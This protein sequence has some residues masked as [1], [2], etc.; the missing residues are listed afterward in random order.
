MWE[1][2][3]VEEEH[4]YRSGKDKEMGD[5]SDH[6]LFKLRMRAMADTTTGENPRFFINS[7]EYETRKV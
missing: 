6:P 7:I 3:R 2:Y 1:E 4:K 5:V